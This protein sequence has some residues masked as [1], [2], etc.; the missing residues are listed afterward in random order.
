MACPTSGQSAPFD[1]GGRGSRGLGWRE[2]VGSRKS[3]EVW[4]KGRW[5]ASRD[6]WANLLK[7]RKQTQ[8]ALLCWPRQPGIKR[9]DEFP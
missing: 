9:S 4:T 6:C 1:S 2:V 7:E 3:P 8:V 5:Q